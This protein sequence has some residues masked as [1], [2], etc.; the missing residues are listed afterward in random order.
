MD[1]RLEPTPAR[2]LFPVSVSDHAGC[3]H[4]ADDSH[5]IEV[6]RTKC[7]GTFSPGLAPLGIAKFYQG[8]AHACRIIGL[9][10]GNVGPEN[11]RKIPDIGDQGLAHIHRI[12]PD[13]RQPMGA[14][15]IQMSLLT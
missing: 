2:K 12:N 3:D 11:G 4:L 5:G 1:E 6:L 13:C 7:P 9:N 14:D 10:D 8:C 15:L